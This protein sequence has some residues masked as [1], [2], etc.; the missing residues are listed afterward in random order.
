MVGTAGS[1]MVWLRAKDLLVPGFDRL[2]AEPTF[3]FGY[4]QGNRVYLSGNP[5]YPVEQAGTNGSAQNNDITGTAGTTSSGYRSGTC[6]PSA[7]A[8]ITS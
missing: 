7:G 2:F 4:F 5:R 8:A 1:A 3:S 6:S